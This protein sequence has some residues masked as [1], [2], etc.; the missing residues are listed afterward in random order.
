MRTGG[1]SPVGAAGD[2][3]TGV[4]QFSD[5][6]YPSLATWLGSPGARTPSI[7]RPCSPPRAAGPAVPVG[8]EPALVVAP[9]D[10][11]PLR[12]ARSRA[13]A[14]LRRRP[15]EGP[16]RGLGRAAGAAVQGPPLPAPAPGRS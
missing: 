14:E 13:V 2:K 10:A 12:D 5:R 9:G 7:H 4:S 15:G 8:D 3:E 16:R 11:G 6:R 1:R